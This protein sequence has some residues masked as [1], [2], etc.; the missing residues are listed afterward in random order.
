MPWVVF[1]QV[2]VYE[3]GMHARGR[4][5]V[6]ANVVLDVI[7]GYGISHR[8]DGALAHGV[9]KAVGE[10][11][12]ACYGSHVENHASA[13][14][15]HVR[16]ALMNTVVDAFYI[17]AEEPVEI[18]FGSSLDGSD[19][20][21]SGVIHQD[22]NALLGEHLLKCFPHLPLV[23]DIARVDGRLAASTGDQLGGRFRLL[24]VD[25]RDSN[26]CAVCR[27]AHGNGLSNAAAGTG[28]DGYLAIQP[29]AADAARCVA[30]RETPRFQ[31]IK[32]SWP[33]DSAF[34]RTSPLAT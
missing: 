7:L 6:A 23:R 30:Q 17:D 20:R 27:K 31:G 29:K 14:R 15:F 4:N 2:I 32:S 11:R 19:V 8:D 21:D 18:L 26:A 9:G 13:V 10:S 12:G 5:A 22:V 24:R 3:R 25:V 16:N 28:N 1:F 33:F 34:V